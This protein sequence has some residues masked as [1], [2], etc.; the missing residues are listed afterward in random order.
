MKSFLLVLLGFVFGGI[1]T[2]ILAS[3]VMT[4]IGAGVGIA[5]GLQAGAC[6]TAEAAKEQGYID[7]EQV[8]DL[9]RAAGRQMASA[10][11]PPDSGPP[12]GDAECAEVVAK[13]KAASAQ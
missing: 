11:A 10:D 3:G 4:G 12:I 7:S 2:F 5:T 13:L 6:L 8:A 1:V 9:L